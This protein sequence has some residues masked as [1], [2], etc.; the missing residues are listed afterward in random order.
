MMT[1]YDALAFVREPLERLAAAGARPSDVRFVALYADYRSILDSGA[2]TSYAV[3]EAARRNGLS[4]RHAYT[5]I[6]RLGKP[7]HG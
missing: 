3:E 1:V 5:V 2:K 4:V 6:A 7:L